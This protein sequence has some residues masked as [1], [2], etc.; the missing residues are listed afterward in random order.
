MNVVEFLEGNGR[1]PNFDIYQDA[2][3]PDEFRNLFHRD[4]VAFYVKFD[5]LEDVISLADHYRSSPKPR[6]LRFREFILA[7]EE[8]YIARFRTQAERE[9][10]RFMIDTGAGIFYPDHRK[11]LIDQY[12]IYFSGA[13]AIITTF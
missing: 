5:I 1:W 7:V 4:W 13:N 9:E 10:K 12:V 3:T 8:A 6:D 2:S 11:D